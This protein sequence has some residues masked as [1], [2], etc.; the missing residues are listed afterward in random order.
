LKNKDFVPPPDLEFELYLDYFKSKLIQ[1]VNDIS[2]LQTSPKSHQK[3]NE[4]KQ[5]VIH[6]KFDVSDPQYQ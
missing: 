2:L 1:K 6:N 3:S 5:A 4:L